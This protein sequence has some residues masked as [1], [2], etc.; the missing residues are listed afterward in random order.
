MATDLICPDCGGVIGGDDSDPRA[1]CQCQMDM[2]LTMDDTEVEAP[3]VDAG[4]EPAPAAAEAKPAATKA[5]KLCCKCG[6]DVT[7]QKRARDTRGYWCWEC[8]RAD[9]R[10]ERGRE[11]PRAR[12][13]Q[14]GRLVP[15]DS[16]TTY[17]GEPMCAKCRIEE[18]EAPNH[19]KLKFKLKQPDEVHK[20]QE[21]KKIYIMAG[22]VAFLLLL[23]LVNHFLRH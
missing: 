20:A 5:P 2:N 13:P 6:K 16:I 23:A 12:C 1:K 7:N 14:C 17:H 21:K 11:K 15:A 19:K 4:S 22:V 18:E 10:Q 9:L 3:A 8:H